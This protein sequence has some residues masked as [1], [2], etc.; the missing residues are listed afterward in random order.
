MFTSRLID[1]IPT[2][3]QAGL[4]NIDTRLAE[5]RNAI[6]PT[7]G[8]DNITKIFLMIY[9]EAI[10]AA[11]KYDVDVTSSGYAIQPTSFNDV[12]RL[13]STI[14]N[15]P[16]ST[17]AV[18]EEFFYLRKDCLGTEVEAKFNEALTEF[19]NSIS[20]PYEE[21]EVRLNLIRE[22]EVE[23]FHSLFQGLFG[24]LAVLTKQSSPPP[25]M[26]EELGA[27]LGEFS[28]KLDTIIQQ[29]SSQSPITEASPTV[30]SL[31]GKLTAETL[32]QAL[33][34]LHELNQVEASLTEENLD[35]ANLDRLENHL[36]ALQ[37]KLAEYAD[38]FNQE[39][40]RNASE[41]LQDNTP[42]V[43]YQ[44]LLEL[45]KLRLLILQYFVSNS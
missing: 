12:T 19:P 2:G 14:I 32:A 18:G 15:F 16:S 20:S 45:Q 41:P 27:R 22:V 5:I 30:E 13:I 10:Y 44:R 26:T 29:S 24:S 23:I 4:G 40:A 17:K 28:Q 31:E 36:Q 38:L 11:L 43:R 21:V 3:K 37:N 35:V 33:P 7:I 39:L 9:L 34:L 1:G 25:Q 42:A 8:Q 6:N